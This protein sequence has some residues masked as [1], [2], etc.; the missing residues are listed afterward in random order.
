MTCGYKGC[1]LP[2]VRDASGNYGRR[3]KTHKGKHAA[4]RRPKKAKKA[5]RKKTAKRAPAQRG[6]RKR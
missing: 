5:K 3:C 6:R 1:K 4:R 2:P